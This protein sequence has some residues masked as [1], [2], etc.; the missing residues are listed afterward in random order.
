MQYKVLPYTDLPVELNFF[1]KLFAVNNFTTWK[2]KEVD[3]RE[4][5]Q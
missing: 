2:Q 1:K 4:V 3:I 5:R